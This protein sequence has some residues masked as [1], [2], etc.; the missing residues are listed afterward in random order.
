MKATLV[1]NLP[2]EDF[3]FQN[4]NFGSHYAGIIEDILHDIREKLKYGELSKKEAQ[5]LEEIRETIRERLS[6][7]VEGF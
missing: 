7:I 6:D 5:M 2:E 4:A 3:E 1:F